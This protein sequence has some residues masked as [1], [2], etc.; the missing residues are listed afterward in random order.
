MYSMKTVVNTALCYMGKLR[1]LALSSHHK[2]NFFS[3]ISIVSL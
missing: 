2:E 3:F 1:E